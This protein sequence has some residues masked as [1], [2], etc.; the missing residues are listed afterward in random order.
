MSGPNTYAITLLSLLVLFVIVG[1]TRKNKLPLPPGPKKIPLLGN[2]LNL[3][4]SQD[5]L[6]YHQWCEDLSA[7]LSLL[8][9]SKD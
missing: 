1:K 9:H 6:T 5:W 4:K 2:L 3:P 8:S 7:S